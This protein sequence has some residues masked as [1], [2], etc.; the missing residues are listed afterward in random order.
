MAEITIT[1][2]DEFEEKVINSDQPVLVDFWAQWCPPCRMMSPV[3]A[4]IAEDMEGK[5]V[6]AK[7]NVEESRDNAE[8]AAKYGVQGIPNMQIFKKGKVV[9]ELVGLQS[10]QFV[11]AELEKLL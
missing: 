2:K 7:I 4:K 9:Q 3:L 8:M 11:R 5:V 6:I 10:E 1:T